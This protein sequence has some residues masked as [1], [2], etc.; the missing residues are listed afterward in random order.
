MLRR[1]IK[2]TPVLGPLS[3]RIYGKAKGF[4]F[5]GSSAYWQRRYRA[6]GNSGHGSYGR[7]AEFKADTLNGFVAEH[8]IESVV[9]FG[10][11]DG[12]QL[13]LASYPRY[14]GLDIAPQAVELCRQR[15]SDDLSK[16][17]A[18]LGSVEPGK[19]DLSMS[20]DVIFHLVE[21]DVF[22]AHMKAVFDAS[23][24]HVVIFSSNEDRSSPE[25]HVRHREFTRWVQ[26]NEPRWYLRKK[27]PNNFSFDEKVHETSFA[28][29][30]FYELEN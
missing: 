7:L 9:E 27:V 5:P 12:A 23:S 17:F 30:Y 28:E 10:C 14:L 8:G 2:S 29:F 1:L 19:H 20:L 18:L 21:D 16:S 13:E 26:D 4:G 11:G 25:P 3:H 22:E 6:G 15:F 24:K